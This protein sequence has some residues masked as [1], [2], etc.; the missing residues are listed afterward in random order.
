LAGRPINDTTG[1]LN[2]VALLKPGAD[3][4]L[5]VVRQR[6]RFDMK[7]IVGRRPTPKAPQ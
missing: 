2:M 7:V 3:V 6:K 5:S 4:P 1:L